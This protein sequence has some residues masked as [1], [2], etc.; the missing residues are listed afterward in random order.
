MVPPF[1]R[2][3]ILVEVTA[4]RNS[5]L[6]GAYICSQ[7]AHLGS[8]ADHCQAFDNAKVDEEF[9]G[10]AHCLLT[11]A[12]YSLSPAAKLNFLCNLGYGDRLKLFPRLLRLAF[13]EACTLLRYR[14]RMFPA[15]IPSHQT[16]SAVCTKG[17]AGI[18]EG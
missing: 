3:R 11:V 14:K 4:R 5:S 6:Q 8:T 10:A 2:P 7:L 17:A 12:Q 18:R 16:R 9:F 15:W 1:C 13:E